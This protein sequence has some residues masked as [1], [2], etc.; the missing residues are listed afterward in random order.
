MAK[1][2]EEVIVIK[3]STLVPDNTDM[4]PI[5]GEDNM[6]ALKQVVEQL[7]GGNRTLVEIERA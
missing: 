6:E 1:L 7:A 2:Q 3:V 5:M 4:S